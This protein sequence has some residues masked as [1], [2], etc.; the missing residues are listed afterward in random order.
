[1]SRFLVAAL[2]HFVSLPDFKNLQT[3]LLEVCK[4]NGVMGTILLAHEG[5]NGTIA[6][7]SAGVHAVLDYIRSDI[8]IAGLEHKES[9]A[10]VENPFNR[11]KVRLKKEIVTMG[12]PSCDPNKIVGTYVKAEDWNDI[13]SDPDV[14]LIDT[15][16]DYE[17]SIGTFKGAIDPKTVNFREF[18]EWVKNQEG[19]GNKPKVAMFCTGGI[20]CEKASSYMKS[21][22][23]EDVYH[24]KGGILQYLEDIPED[25]SMWEG[26]CFVFDDRVSVGHGLT[27][28]PYDLCHACRHPI[29]EEE[30]KS[31]K[32]AQGV[33]CHRCYDEMSDEKRARFE[34]RQLQVTLAKERGTGHIAVDQKAQREAKK[35]AKLEQIEKS[36]KGE[37]V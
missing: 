36:K 25:K 13:I 17:V 14:V 27:P 30:K 29:S 1:M 32:Y 15:R 11:M 16:N 23:F 5:I 26:E 6:G 33:S 10:E 4:V 8:R 7:P 28:G 3:P 22:G 18:P 20:R 34:Q 9:Y 37:S 2:Y 19:L 12:V 31:D 21:E 35:A 24:L